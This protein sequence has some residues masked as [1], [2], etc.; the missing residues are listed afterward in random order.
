MR[1]TTRR[2]ATLS[3]WQIFR[4]PLLLGLVS[5]AGLAAALM[6]NGAWDVISWL[7]LGSLIVLLYKRGS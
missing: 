3:L 5:I 1:A 7:C 4:W 2:N 6:G